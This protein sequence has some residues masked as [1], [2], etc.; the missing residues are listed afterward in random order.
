MTV[1]DMRAA[2]RGADPELFFSVSFAD[3][4]DV[5]PSSRPHAAVA[6]RYCD[7]CPVR[8]EC[9]AAAL[10]EEDTAPMSNRFGLRAGLTPAQRYSVHKR[11]AADC[12][13]CGCAIDPLCFRTGR[14]TCSVCNWHRNVQPVP[15][16]GDEWQERHTILAD[17]VLDWLVRNS[18][19]NEQLPSPHALAKL[20]DVRK[21]D[22]GRVYEAF[23]FSKT[24]RRQGVHY[25]RLATD[26]QLAAWAPP[27]LAA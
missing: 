21:A 15:E 19:P 23:L 7:C 18:Y 6:D 24:I 13:E 20:L 2:C 4:R 1:W 11:N 9:L 16:E 10:L 12:P 14:L 5:W 8:R 27:H 26:A 17:R 22:V 25:V 3:G